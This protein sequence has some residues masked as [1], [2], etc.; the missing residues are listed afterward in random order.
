MHTYNTPQLHVRR[1]VSD[2]GSD[3][4]PV[5]MCK[6]HK[7]HT[8]MLLGE[9]MNDT[10]FA[11]S[12]TEAWNRLHEE[13]SSEGGI[14]MEVRMEAAGDNVYVCPCCG[15]EKSDDTARDELTELHKAMYYSEDFHKDVDE[16]EYISYGLENPEW[17]ELVA[18]QEADEASWT[19][20]KA[21]SLI[22]EDLALASTDAG[23][24]CGDLMALDW[25]GTEMSNEELRAL[26]KYIWIVKGCK[27]SSLRLRWN[28]DGLPMTFNGKKWSEVWGYTPEL[29]ARTITRSLGRKCR[30][31]CIK[32]FNGL[33]KDPAFHSLIESMDTEPEC[34]TL[35]IGHRIIKH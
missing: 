28:D 8:S 35:V 21:G 18:E 9:W 16:T 26:R 5:R 6:Q 12:T 24:S 1:T 20:A 23:D 31:Y 7:L 14:M 27:T 17:M 15:S 2:Q 25:S 32:V 33:M 13:L 19:K 34:G 29:R 11:G 4:G 30:D 3:Y 10:S 22:S